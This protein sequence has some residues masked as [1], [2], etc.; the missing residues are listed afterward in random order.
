MFLDLQIATTRSHLSIF[1]FDSAK[2]AYHASNKWDYIEQ[3]AL[4]LQRHEAMWLWESYLIWIKDRLSVVVAEKNEENN[5]AAAE[6]HNVDNEEDVIDNQ[7]HQQQ[8]NMSTSKEFKQNLNYFL[9][10]WPLYPKTTVD[11][12]VLNFGTI[13]F[14]S[15]L[16]AFLHWNFPGMT[17]IPSIHNWPDVYR[18]LVIKLPHNPYVSDLEHMQKDRLWTL[19][20]VKANG[21][22]PGRLAHFALVIEDF[23]L[24]E[25][26]GGIAGEFFF[27]K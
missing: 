21:R 25:S 23:Q 1:T 5:E 4:W 3:M 2:E 18:Q 7:Q 15:V 6:D 19:P 24:H 11:K 12:I 13:E 10:T 9:T 22:T 14:V 8:L 27:N 26:D 20:F 17:I 16:S